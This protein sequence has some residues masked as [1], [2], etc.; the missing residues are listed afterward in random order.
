MFSKFAIIK[1]MNHYVKKHL[2]I[3]LV[4]LI[5]FVAIIAGIY[6]LIIKSTLPDCSDNIQNQ[7]ETGVDCGGP[8][9]RC[10]WQHEDLQIISS[11]A[12]KPRDNYVDLVASLKNPN[13][14][15][16]VKIL[17]YAFNLYNS[18]NN[19]I[20]FKQGAS[21][22]LPGETKYIIEQKILVN[23]EISRVEFKIINTVWQKL[24][25]F[26]EPE[27]LIRN[28]NFTLTTDNIARAYGT[29]ENKS[30]Y[31]FEKINVYIILLDK[32]SKILGVAQT[33]ER[34]V[35]SKESRYFEINWF[36][37]LAGQVEKFDIMAKTNVF[38]DENFMKKQGQPEI[39][40]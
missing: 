5:I 11:Q 32:D 1:L 23:E 9:S 25:G 7:G 29:L 6:F 31:D 27:L 26:E 13:P 38:I 21:Y 22:I 19:L 40:Q 36:Y 37:P 12:I 39:L 18:N 16:G 17:S 3:G 28:S 33:E 15:F 8:C 2:K 14:D 4:W 24:A 35:V 10:P 20:S 34:T 30:N